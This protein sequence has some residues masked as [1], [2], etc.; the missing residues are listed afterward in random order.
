MTNLAKSLIL[1]AMLI[2][3]PSA[4]LFAQ[5]GGFGGR[6]AGGGG[7]RGGRGAG[8]GGRGSRGGDAS[9]GRASFGG[10]SRGGN[11]GGGGFS[12]GGNTGGGGF[13]RGGNS[14]TSG[15]SRGGGGAGSFGGGRTG[16]FDPSRMI[17]GFAA[18]LDSNGDG[19][20]DAEE[21]KKIPSQWRDRL[22]QQGI[23]VNR[24]VALSKFTEVATRGAQ[25]RMRQREGERN[26][27]STTGRNGDRR[28][29]QTKSNAPS[30]QLF[31][32]PE[33][34]KVF[35][36]LSGE[37]KEADVD[38]DGMV[39]LYEWDGA[40]MPFEQFFL[41]DTNEDGYVSAKEAAGD[42][43]VDAGRFL[44]KNRVVIIGGN[45]G[46][47]SGGRVSFSSSPGSRGGATNSKFAKPEED[48]KKAAEYTKAMDKNGNGYID[49]EEWAA[50]RRLRPWFEKEGIKVEGMSA[51]EF[52][53]NYQKVMA[54]YREQSEKRREEFRNRGGG[55]R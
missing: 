14:G 50:S 15:F 6:G 22:G 51:S 28:G 11:T 3:L 35:K 37:M 34:L 10:F 24:T 18:R 40:G 9:S 29:S 43:E 17:S 36:E 54:K 48:T 23:D 42:L 12:R 33:R 8:G 49:K 47:A 2:S 20:L 13:T 45:S 31:K 53:Q 32:M 30:V 44:A 39:A 55:G 21:M 16:G 7:E 4:E 1:T 27:E 25:E 5:R 52:S 19:N 46:S 26:G 38:G 41:K